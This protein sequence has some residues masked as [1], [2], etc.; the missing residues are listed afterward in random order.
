MIIERDLEIPMNDGL[1][2]KA[3]V[4]RP[5]TSD[6]VP[7][8]LAGGPYGKGVKYQEHYKR[9]WDSLVEM[10]PDVLKNSS[11][12]YLTWE[13]VDPEI[14]VPWG[15]A[16]VRFDSRGAGRS[17]GFLDIFSPRET[18]DFATV[19]EWCGTQEWSNGA[20]GLNGISY[21]AINQWQVAAL[22][23][24]HLKAMIPWEGA[25][26]HYR[27]WARHGGIL[28]NHF[29][30]FWFPSQVLAIQHGNPN[31][32]T[33]HW[34]TEDKGEQH[35]STGPSILSER[36]RKENH[37]HTLDNFRA[38]ELDD[39]WYQQRSPNWDNVEVP[40]LSAASWAGFGLHPR[41]NFEAFIQ[42]KSADKW[43][44][45]HPGRHEEW[46][47]L[48]YGM[49]L[50]KRFF[51]FYLKDEKNGWDK[52]P[53]VW[54]NLRRPFSNEFKLRKENEWP[55]ERTKWTKL[56]IDA[57]Q[58]GSL[59]WKKNPKSAEINFSSNS[60]GI[61]ILSDPLKSETEITGPIVAKLFVSSSTEDCDI[62]ITLQAFSETGKE[63]YFQGTVDPRTPLAQGWLRASHRKL[64]KIK[65]LFWR[66]Y[67]SHDEK[68]MLLPNEIYEL[69]IEI[70]PQS[71]ILPKGYQIGINISGQDFD[72]PGESVGDYMPCRGSGPFLHNDPFDRPKEIFSGETTIY[73]GENHTSYILLPIIP[74]D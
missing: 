17:Q 53:K 57:S 54:L 59:S 41:G 9:L 27:D 28:S 4:Y 74:S 55:L 15:Y 65:S 43:L 47:Y 73:S 26:D 44:E 12:K 32:P 35:L 56:F 23:P 2:L 34:L 18:E 33:D 5:E 11:Q 16:C 66:P 24:K 30:E 58:N 37:A 38:R 69:D 40:F 68:Q 51:D 3:D 60:R 14:W 45:V 48:E 29:M 31:G 22:K 8:I 62:F 13:T 71:I 50:Q 70:W 19:I 21:Y 46:F 10:H 67:H 42:A 52:E 72:R 39:E 61:S 20:V 36:E 1:I 7:V 49:Q 63:V 64:D 25:A 6:K